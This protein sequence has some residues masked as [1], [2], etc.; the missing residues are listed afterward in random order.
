[1]NGKIQLMI[2]LC[3][4]IQDSYVVLDKYKYTRKHTTKR[5][6]CPFWLPINRN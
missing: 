4:V 3:M 2:G 1:M 5:P 6:S